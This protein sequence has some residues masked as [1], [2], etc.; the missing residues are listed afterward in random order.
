MKLLFLNFHP[1]QLEVTLEKIKYVGNNSEKL[2]A[3]VPI[4]PF[5]HPLWNNIIVN[6]NKVIADRGNSH[7]MGHSGQGIKVQTQRWFFPLSYLFW[8]VVHSLFSY[9]LDLAGPGPRPPGIDWRDCICRAEG[10]WVSDW[11]E[12]LLLSH[13][14]AQKQFHF[15]LWQAKVYLVW[16]V[17]MWYIKWEFDQNQVVVL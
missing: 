10:R 9:W 16:Q 11:R 1:L 4:C 15:H 17:K 8:I 14:V 12:V 5:P 7:W 3:C 2:E 6:G 13:Y